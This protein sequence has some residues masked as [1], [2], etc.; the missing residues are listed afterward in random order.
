VLVEQLGEIAAH[1]EFGSP[2]EQI[3]AVEIVHRRDFDAVAPLHL[4]T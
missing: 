2:P 1:P 3:G 4:R